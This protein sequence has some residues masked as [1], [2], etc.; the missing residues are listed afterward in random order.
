[1]AATTVRW[2]RSS[3][4]VWVMAYRECSLER[5]IF[6]NLLRLS[7]SELNIKNPLCSTQVLLANRF[8][9]K[10]YFCIIAI[11]LPI[12]IPVIVLL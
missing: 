10:A 6:S 7:I 8:H 4:L 3:Y 2:L 12:H 9:N 1:M 11:L 5:C